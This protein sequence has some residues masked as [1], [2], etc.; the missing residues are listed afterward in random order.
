MSQILCK[1]VLEGGR[2]GRGFSSKMTVASVL[3]TNKVNE[4]IGQITSSTITSWNREELSRCH[5]MTNALRPSQSYF[6]TCKEQLVM[7]AT[8]KCSVESIR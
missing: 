4:S 2:K 3:I 8:W 1:K 5:L 7:F 6:P